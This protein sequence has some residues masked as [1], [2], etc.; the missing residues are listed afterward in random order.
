MLWTYDVASGR[1]RDV[2]VSDADYV[3]LHPGRQNVFT[4]VHHSMSRS[5]TLSARAITSP[6]ETLSWISVKDEKGVIRGDTTVWHDLPAAYVAQGVWD[7]YISQR[8]ILVHAKSQEIEVQRF[9]WF[10][11]TYD[12]VYQRILDV[13]P[14][15]NS[16]YV[17]ISIQRDS[18]LVLYDP[19]TRIAIRRIAL[20]GRAGNPAFQFRQTAPEL[21]AVDYDMLVRVESTQWLLMDALKVQQSATG[22]AQFVGG[23]AFDPTERL[24]AIARP[25]SGDVIALD[26]KTFQVSHRA[27]T[28]REPIEVVVLR[29]GHVFGRD[30]HTGEMLR[31]VLAPINQ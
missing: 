5:P 7:G 23:F 31:G 11:E 12:H 13:V 24:C 18:H 14:V 25:A 8:L 19:R 22:T 2:T 17:V 30:W 29:D 1:T 26:T 20:T 28:G 21:W 3:S 27:E 16:P 15:P 6:G 4:C 10:D 9:D